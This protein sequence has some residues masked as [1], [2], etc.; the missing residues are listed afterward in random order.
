MAF[1]TCFFYV[2]TWTDLVQVGQ[3]EKRGADQRLGHGDPGEWRY[4]EHD[5]GN[6]EE[7]HR[8]TI[9]KL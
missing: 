2:F 9:G 6:L 8:K 3:V 4:P 5:S 7:T 1:Q